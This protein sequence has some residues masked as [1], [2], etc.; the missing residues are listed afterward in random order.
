MFLPLQHV[1][2]FELKGCERKL[3]CS[4]ILKYFQ[5]LI[6]FSSDTY[7]CFFKAATLCSRPS[8]CKRALEYPHRT[9]FPS[10]LNC[11]TW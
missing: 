5:V 8:G 6:V 4:D 3:K 11:G 10:E 9:A 7:F 2:E 1:F